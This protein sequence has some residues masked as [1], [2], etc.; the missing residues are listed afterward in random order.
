MADVIKASYLLPDLGVTI[1]T[2]WGGIPM[3]MTANS[4]VTNYP[5]MFWIEPDAEGIDRLC[6]PVVMDQKFPVISVVGDEYY[7]APFVCVNKTEGDRCWRPA[8]KPQRP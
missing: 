2:S 8:S 3:G 4:M 6:C 5:N 1:I 7:A